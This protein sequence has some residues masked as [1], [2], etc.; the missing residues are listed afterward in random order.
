MRYDLTSGQAASGIRG[1]A[2]IDQS[3][4]V[5]VT[6]YDSFP[7]SDPPAWIATGISSPHAE[8]TLP[9]TPGEETTPPP[10]GR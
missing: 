5:D 1:Y 10:T 6:S 8:S 2:A 3:D 4:Q 7:A 9:P